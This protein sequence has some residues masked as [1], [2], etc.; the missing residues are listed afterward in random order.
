MSRTTSLLLG[1]VAVGLALA[2]FASGYSTGITGV[3]RPSQGCT[4]HGFAG[5]TPN[6]TTDVSVVGL[7]DAYVPGTTYHLQAWVRGVALP[8]PRFAGFDLEAT[9]GALQALDASAWVSGVDGQATHSTPKPIGL[10]GATGVGSSWDIDWVAPD[11][12][13]GP[14]TFYL[15]GNVV[16]GIG[17]Q[18]NAD[19]GDFWSVANPG[20][21][22]AQ[23]QIDVTTTTTPPPTTTTTTTTT[24]TTRGC[25]TSPQVTTT[26]LAGS[27]P[28]RFFD[29]QNTANVG[30]DPRLTPANAPDLTLLARL[31]ADG[32]PT[33]GVT[34]VNHT[35]V[36]GDQLVFFG[37]MVG[38]FYVYDV[39]GL[40]ASPPAPPRLLARIATHTAGPV[41]SALGTYTGVQA[42][43][44]LALVTNPN[45][46]QDEKRLYFGVDRVDKTLWCLNVDKI[47]ADRS[48]IPSGALCEDTCECNV[49]GDCPADPPGCMKDAPSACQAY[50]CDGPWPMSLGSPEPPVDLGGDRNTL[51]GSPLFAADMPF[52][53]GP[54][55]VLYVPSTGLD[56]SN[57]QFYAIDAFTGEK[58][59]T[60]DPVVNGDGLG[61]VIWTAPA[62]SKDR[63]Q[64]FMTVGDCVQKPQVG[65]L[66]E[67]LV[68]LDPITGARQWWHQRRL[69]DVA[70]LDIGNSPTVVDVDG[71]GGCHLIVSIDKDSCIYGFPQQPDVPQVGDLDFDPLRVGQQRLLWRTC[72]AYGSLGGGFDAAGGVLSGRTLAAAAALPFGPLAGDDVNAFAIDACTGAF[73]WASSTLGAS[74][75]EG[76][77]ASGMFFMPTGTR[78]DVVRMDSPID[79]PV[80]EPVRTSRK[81]ELLATV[82]L[83]AAAT[84][85]GGGPAIVGGRIYVPVQKG[86][87]IV[88]VDPTAP[89]TCPEAPSCPAPRGS[90]MFHGPYPE[91]FAPGAP[92]NPVVLPHPYDWMVVE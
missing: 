16:N 62:M 74:F 84:P 30:D 87:A 21:L 69:V 35:P 28:R 39:S 60:F 9:A 3:A 83:P 4:C 33:F 91:P 73:K 92:G 26:T 42:T 54:R 29:A 79:V 67:A 27:W 71:T 15:A 76:A 47:I 75:G 10:V 55:D 88:G 24:L 82:A 41:G 7:P 72:F 14:V 66:A 45:T 18:T 61:G 56:C 43:P 44:N 80:V 34:V 81:P 36:V 1:V 50:L 77:A 11:P 65:E 68:S 6:T 22:V 59:W 20:F 12:G 19:Q 40:D 53:N 63:T 23:A 90:D 8:A 25:G 37:D 49:N 46:G 52:P 5:V 57:G 31:L 17:L 64:L 85:G 51:N 86:I 70:D 13:V 48:A 38:W 2:P 32:P 78:L 89:A 58:L